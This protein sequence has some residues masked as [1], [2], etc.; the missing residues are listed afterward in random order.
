M[1]KRNAFRKRVNAVMRSSARDCHYHSNVV[2]NDTFIS[3]VSEDQ[4]DELLLP[5]ASPTLD[6]QLN[7]NV[8]I[9]DVNTSGL[10][11]SYDVN[12]TPLEQFEEKIVS[13]GRKS[14]SKDNVE[15]E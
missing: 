3:L 2:G 6:Q 5:I 7:A 1:E 14:N 4:E 15:N 8:A 9:K 13:K 11:D 10:L 12:D